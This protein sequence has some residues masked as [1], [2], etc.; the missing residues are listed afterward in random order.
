MRTFVAL[1]LP[2]AFA[3]DVAALARRLSAAVEGR[4][5]PRERRHLTLAFVGDIDESGV[6]R[7]IEALEAACTG[8]APVPLR[9]EG[10]G[11]F[12]RAN[13]ATLWLGIALGIALAPELAELAARIRAELSAR[14]VPFDGKPF[15][16]H[17]TLARRARI[18]KTS[19]AGLAFP[20]E[21]EARFVT[22]FKSMLGR[23][24]PTYKPLHT[25]DLA[26]STRE[27]GAE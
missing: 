22:L 7:A 15:K 26:A 12:G 21:D 11:R 20:R 27:L 18:P 25:R 8:A 23:E 1:E 13:D 19:L 17:V 6:E 2:D 10:L 16:P 3:S 5:V 24:G 4:F 9:S 14:G